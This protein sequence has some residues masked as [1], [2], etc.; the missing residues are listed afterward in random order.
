L[1]QLRCAEPAG[2]LEPC[3]MIGRPASVPFE[4]AMKT[5]AHQSQRIAGHPFQPRNAGTKRIQRKIRAHG[6]QFWLVSGL[7]I[8]SGGRS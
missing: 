4:Y 7:L 1:H 3:E 8:N 5:A 6:T 2:D